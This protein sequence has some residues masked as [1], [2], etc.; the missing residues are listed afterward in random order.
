[1]SRT[2]TVDT[3]QGE[4]RP[5]A[6]M[7]RRQTGARHH[8]ALLCIRAKHLVTHVCLRCEVHSIQWGS[9]VLVL[10]AVDGRRHPVGTAGHNRSSATPSA[11]AGSQARII[12]LGCSSGALYCL[13][14]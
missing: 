8:L 6:A 7:S 1:M 2:E 14:G 3:V 5:G 11:K 4:A 9:F 12:R 13:S 10:C